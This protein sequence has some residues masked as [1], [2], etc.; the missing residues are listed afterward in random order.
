MSGSAV[1]ILHP[2][3]NDEGKPVVIYEPSSPSDPESWSDPRRVVTITPGSTV[4]SILNGIALRRVAAPSSGAAWSALVKDASAGPY[5]SLKNPRHKKLSS[6]AVIF[7][8]DG[9]V[10]VFEPTNK[11]GG[12]VRTFPKGTAEPGLSLAANAAKEVFEETGLL[13][14]V[15]QPLIDTE[16]TASVCRYFVGR[17]IGGDPSNMGWEAQAVCLTPVALLPQYVT[18]VSDMRVIEVIKELASTRTI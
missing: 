17:R 15:G 13:I 11:Y 3:V 2:K 9:R 16:R 14:E 1:Q 8:P 7:E 10:W 5:P 6:G 18:H 4:P 12:Y